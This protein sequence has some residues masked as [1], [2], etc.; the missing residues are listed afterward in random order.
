[1]KKR[2]EIPT[3][4]ASELI[5]AYTG[6]NV[7][8]SEIKWATVEANANILMYQDARDD[9]IWQVRPNGMTSHKG[10]DAGCFWTDWER[11]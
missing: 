5:R 2:N 9:T 4:Q 11:R 1:M 7:K 6:F 10:P 8:P 3:E